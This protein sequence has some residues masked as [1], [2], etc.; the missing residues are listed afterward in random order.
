VIDF[1]RRKVM[2]LQQD[3]PTLHEL[4]SRLAEVEQANARLHEE[5]GALRAERSTAPEQLVPRPRKDHVGTF[6]SSERGIPAVRATG[7]NSADGVDATSDSGS[8]VHAFS[9]S[10]SGVTAI[11]LGGGSGVFAES[12]SGSGV[13]AS[14]D[15]SDGVDAFSGSGNGVFA[16]SVSGFGLHAIGPGATPNPSPFFKQAAIFAEGNPG[17][18]AES[19]NN[20]GT[21][22][23]A[24]SNTGDGVVGIS[25]GNG[26]GVAAQSESGFG[27][28]TS[29]GSGVGLRAVSQ[30]GAD[31]VFAQSASG[32]GLHAVGGGATP[33]PP[34]SPG[35]AAI[36]AEGGP[37]FGVV[38]IS[39]LAGVF[40]QSNLG[41]GVTG[42][43][44]GSGDGVHAV[45][46]LGSGIFALGR[47]AGFF[48]GDVDI[49]GTLTKSGGGFKVDHPF[50]PANKYLSHSFVESPDMKNVY[51]GEVVLNDRGEAEV[52]LPG[53]FEA[54]NKAFRYQLTAIGTSGPDLYIAEEI[55]NQRFKIAGGKPHMKVCWQVTGIRQDAWAKEYPLPV[56]QDK[57]EQE[58][59]YYLHPELYG[60]AEQKS[61]LR[62]R[63]PELEIPMLPKKQCRGGL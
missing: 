35:P 28:D 9:Q 39:D 3:E 56:E 23:F 38:V 45:S 59:G 2:S 13:H 18:F 55:S 40:A 14:S 51:D 53:W 21:D 49:T 48:F 8:G 27:V 25:L 10:G 26:R 32:F 36:L 52:L 11:S 62:A 60:E 37:A 6:S 22:V 1:K 24:Q 58:Q 33:D 4:V 54:L 30:S 31:G 16:E 29:S 5:L 19:Q 41:S 63:Y 12:V 50:D 46:N 47:P 20:F 15:S 17:V 57:P 44:L 7:T 43:S 42:R 34:P 61:I